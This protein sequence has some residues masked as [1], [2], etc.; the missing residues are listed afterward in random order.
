MSRFDS[1]QQRVAEHDLTFLAGVPYVFHCHHFN[2]FH[3]QTIDDVLGEEEGFRLRARVARDVFGGL[4]RRLCTR[5]DIQTPAEKAELA[6]ELFAKMGQGRLPVVLHAGQGAEAQSATLHY[7]YTWHAK[8]GEKVRRLDPVDAVAAGVLAAVA[9][10]ADGRGEGP[11]RWRGVETRCLAQRHAQCELRTEPEPPGTPL[12]RLPLVDED[13]LRSWH[14]KV[15]RDGLDEEL[16]ARWAASLHEAACGLE[17]NEDGLLPVFNVF[18]TQHL[19]G[20]YNETGFAA[21]RR[22]EAI[23]P[24]VAEAAESLLREAGHVCVFNT[25]GN[26]LLSDL[27]PQVAEPLSGDP[28]Q[29]VRAGCAI[30]RAL[31]FGRWSLQ[32][33]L[34]G[35]RL[36]VHTH[37][38][39]EAPHWLAR[40]G[41]DTKSRSYF[42]QGAVQAFMV[43]AERVQW[44]ER[45]TL[46]QAFYDALF[47]SEGGL[48]VRV[49]AP[50]CLT[51]GDAA[52]TV[53]VEHIG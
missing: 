40:F 5:F 33:Y 43:L 37:T 24:S 42:M 11:P 1:L 53:V 21:V 38:N 16:I 48:G 45:P 35:K 32:E 2:L 12:V 25:F 44:A 17:P 20:Y 8:Y 6:A 49:E 51:K 27:W 46:D 23:H 3:D 50:E 15:P 14:G 52:T 13:A 18:V 22:L 47:R 41:P 36:V 7:G 4:L 30:A 31:G 10:C 19:A 26:I 39:Y 34:P 29:I 28:Q 9:E